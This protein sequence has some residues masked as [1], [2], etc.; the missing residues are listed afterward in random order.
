M[1]LARTSR[2]TLSGCAGTPPAGVQPSRPKKKKRRPKDF[3]EAET[4]ATGASA[5]LDGLLH[6]E[7]LGHRILTKVRQP[8]VVVGDQGVRRGQRNHGGLP[9]YDRRAG[10]FANALWAREPVLVTLVAGLG[11]EE[12]LG[13]LAPAARVM[14]APGCLGATFAPGCNGHDVS[15]GC[16]ASTGW[17][18]WVGCRRRVGGSPLAVNRVMGDHHLLPYGLA[19]TDFV[20]SCARRHPPA[21]PDPGP[22]SSD[23]PGARSPGESLPSAPR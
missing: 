19:G 17:G 12:H 20:P 8:G 1:L 4:K 6:P 5:N 2:A 15:A 18:S 14:I 23:A 10:G 3:E 13:A 7:Q 11:S 9:A 16:F 21:E 22:T